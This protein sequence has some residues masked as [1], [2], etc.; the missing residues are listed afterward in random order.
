MKK[1]VD[2]QIE[3][4][5]KRAIKDVPMKQ[6]GKARKQYETEFQRKKA[7]KLTDNFMRAEPLLI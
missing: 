5:I 4:E 1:L 3:K 6:R 2:D 7:Q